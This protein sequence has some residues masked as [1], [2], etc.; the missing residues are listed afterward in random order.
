MNDI[1]G[2]GGTPDKGGDGRLALGGDKKENSERECDF[3]WQDNWCRDKRSQI[4]LSMAICN[5][6]T[7]KLISLKKMVG[8]LNGGECSIFGRINFTT[9]SQIISSRLNYQLVMMGGV[10]L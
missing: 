10:A 8:R 4:Y 9:C 3:F 7:T 2:I 5:I 1:C 6:R